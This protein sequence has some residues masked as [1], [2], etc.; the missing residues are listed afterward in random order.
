MRQFEK[1]RLQQNDS[2]SANPMI[3]RQPQQ[4]AQRAI[5]LGAM[6]M[7]GSL[8]LTD[9]PRTAEASARLLPWLREVDCDGEIDRIEREELMT[10]LG[11]LS[12]SQRIDVNWAGEAA[13][14]F[15]WAL[16]L[17]DALDWTNPADQSAVI[18]T[19]RILHADALELQRRATV[20]PACELD[21]ACRQFVLIRS[22]LQQARISSPGKE[23]IAKLALQRLADVGIAVSD[24][25]IAQAVATVAAMTPQEQSRAAGIY[26]VR[27]HA[28]LWLFNDSRTYFE[29]K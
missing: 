7:R 19:L 3:T 28:A 23:V 15:C 20:R 22:T 1:F 17:D 29:Q 18:G 24:D 27:C 6:A 8:E 16:G 9:H 25:A 21:E 13:A 2:V 5:V 11:G 26:F 4:I 12:P 10:P 14:F